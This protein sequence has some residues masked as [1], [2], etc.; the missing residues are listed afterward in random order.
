M[1]VSRLGQYVT[2]MLRSGLVDRNRLNSI[3]QELQQDKPAERLTISMVARR[4]IDLRLIT[5]WNH[6]LLMKGCTEGFLIG[7]YKL[8]YP[9]GAGGMCRVFLVEHGQLRR[10]MALKIMSSESARDPVQVQRFYLEARMLGR[11]NH[12]GIITLHDVG[13]AAGRHF[14]ALE[15]FPGVDMQ[16]LVDR[17]GMLP[18]KTAAEYVCQIADALDHLHRQRLV[19]RDVKPANML[20][21]GDGR[22][23]LIDM[24]LALD[25]EIDHS[26]TRIQRAEMLGTTDYVAPEQIEDCHNVGRQADVYSLGCTLYFLLTGRPPFPEGS[27]MQRLMC[28]QG[29]EPPPVDKVRTTVPDKLAKL[30][31]EMLVKDPLR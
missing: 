18:C 4:L 13:R 17:N 28:H 11:L 29:I 7:G 5:L 14:M 22:V 9:L 12:S 25:Q 30:C 2:L 23:K 3:V 27:M 16:Q 15:Y 1:K 6:R 10:R 26:L 31:H 19:H 24:G 21:S 8:L 20:A